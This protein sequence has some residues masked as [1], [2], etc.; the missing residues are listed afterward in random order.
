[1]MVKILVRHHSKSYRDGGGHALHENL[2]HLST[3]ARR[4]A[5]LLAILRHCAQFVNSNF[6]SYKYQCYTATN[7][8]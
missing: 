5:R 2:S 7:E 3:I 4:W 6:T 1:M 8:D